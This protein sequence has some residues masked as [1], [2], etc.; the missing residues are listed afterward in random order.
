MKRLFVTG[1]IVLAFSSA[2]LGSDIYIKQ[3]SHTDGFAMMG[4]ETPAKDE[5]YHM[6]LGD[7]KLAMQ[8]PSMSLVVN[9]DDNLMYW[10]NH[11]SKNYVEM[12]LPLDLD[13]YFPEQ[14]RQ[15]MKNVEV[16]VAPSGE[17]KKVG[18]WECEGYDMSLNFMG[19]DMKQKMWTS[20]QVP[21]DWKDYA[22]KLMPKLYEAMFQLGD[23][24]LQE[25]LKIEGFLIRQETTMAMMGNE[26]KSWQEVIEIE[27]KSAP[28]G[29]YG[30]PDG[31][32]KKD[33]LDFMDMQR[34]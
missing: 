6:W 23:E 22:E 33:K 1:L 20:T 11:E 29:T 15:M 28:A 5:F 25:L 17:K 13:K 32:T 4:Q 27:K 14:M 3:K 7:N 21:F 18:E 9:M 30:V 10:I 24:S 8:M 19:M 34:R 2:L 31:Y 12:E 16:S 26:I